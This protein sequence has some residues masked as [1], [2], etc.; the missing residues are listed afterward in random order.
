MQRRIAVKD[1]E[2]IASNLSD[3]MPSFVNARFFIT[4]GTGFIGKWLLETIIYLNDYHAANCSAVVLSRNSEK[5]LTNYPHFGHQ[6]LTYING[7]IK[8]FVFPDGEF[9]YCIHAALEGE[10]LDNTDQLAIIDSAYIGTQRVLEFCRL[11]NI[12][13]T[14]FISSGGIYGRQMPEIPFV[15][16]TYIGAPDLLQLRAAYGEAKRISEYLCTYYARQYGV[17]IK[18]AR[19]F[20]FSG[21]YLPLNA[22]FVFGNFVRN[23]IDNVP[24]QIKGD[25]TPV[26]SYMYAADLATYLFH[27]LV[28]GN[29]LT[30]YNI[31]SMEEVSILNL[32][33]KMA[34]IVSPSPGIAVLQNKTHSGLPE[35]YVPDTTRLTLKFQLK[36]IIDLDEQI[37]RTINFYTDQ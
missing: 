31:G 12:T 3:I 28:Q 1:L 10:Q 8:T 30:P 9:N 27:I 5:F 14:L 4:G 37:K 36:G 24:L 21:P 35:R 33:N 26:R 7:D 22:H 18:I 15:N 2:H 32:A 13:A 16:E 29:D 19:P 25:G 17:S 20:A 6:S 34:S 11:T 23:C